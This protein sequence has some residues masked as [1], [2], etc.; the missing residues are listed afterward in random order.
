MSADVGTSYH[1]PWT[2]SP[3][4]SPGVTGLGALLITNLLTAV[5]DSQ[6]QLMGANLYPPDT[7]NILDSS[8]SLYEDVLPYFKKSQNFKPHERNTPGSEN[9]SDDNHGK[10]GYLPVEPF[11]YRSPIMEGLVE[12]VKEC[13]YTFGD[14]NGPVQSG[15]TIQHGTVGGGTRANTA[16]AFLAPIK[17]RKNFH[18]AKYAHVTKLLIDSETKAVT[19]VEFVKNG[20]LYTVHSSKEVILSGGTINSAQLLMLSGVG[21]R[22][23]LK[24]MGINV[25]QDLKVGENLQDHMMALAPTFKFN[26]SNPVPVDNL[27]NLDDTYQFLI[28]RRG[29]LSSV[30]VLHLLG[31]ISTKYAHLDVAGSA[32]E[33]TK[34]LDYPDIQYQFIRFAFQDKN[35]TKI[36]SDSVGFTEDYYRAM[37]DTPNSESEILIPLTVLQRPKSRGV[38]KL[39]SKDPKDPPVIDPRYLSDPRDVQTLIEGIKQ[40]VNIARAKA[41]SRF[42]VEM[43]EVKVPGCEAETFG[44][45]EYWSCAV[46]RVAT[47]IYHPVGTCKMGPRSDP[48]A[49]VDSRLRVHGIKGLR[50]IDGSVMPTV[51]SGNTQ[52]SIIMIGERGAD[53]IKDDWLS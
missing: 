29:P 23:H 13:G 20:K 9:Y 16:K 37:F 47:T 24:E 39:R 6:N 22:G 38:I 46:R 26:L 48:D 21:P 32:P 50:V 2:S 51:V 19:G 28:H 11:R 3:S 43:S 14:R 33:D 27:K 36:F 7:T 52:A 1:S 31:F 5:I 10:G 17:G 44:S 49:V 18:V 53:F 40:I 35:A 25:I 12:A 42:E 34:D 15:F 8:T 41:L 4:C 45:D 30:D